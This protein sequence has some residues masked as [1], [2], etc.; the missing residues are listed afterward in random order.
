MNEFTFYMRGVLTD[1]LVLVQESPFNHASVPTLLTAS[2]V[3]TIYC[4]T[5]YAES[6]RLLEN[7]VSTVLINVRSTRLDNCMYVLPV[8]KEL[9]A[10]QILPVQKELNADHLSLNS[11]HARP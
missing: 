9:N 7:R 5:E 2:R 8:R 6:I 1:I 3:F 10:D 11:S 4:V